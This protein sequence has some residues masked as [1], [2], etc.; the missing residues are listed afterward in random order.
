MGATGLTW[1]R[2][3]LGLRRI[4]VHRHRDPACASREELPRRSELAGHTNGD[5]GSALGARSA[6]TPPG[7]N[8]PPH[9]PLRLPRLAE[10]RPARQCQHSVGTDAIEG[11]AAGRAA[12]A[13][14]HPASCLPA[15]TARR[16]PPGLGQ[17][18][19]PCT[20]FRA[21]RLRSQPEVGAGAW[22]RRSREA[23]EEVR[24]DGGGGERPPRGRGGSRLSARGGAFSPGQSARGRRR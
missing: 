21:C 8:Q 18:S 22:P 5:R 2:G 24:R 1:Q 9:L 3:G 15:P 7:P 4:L 6:Q 19:T 17:R 14:L 12:S 23:A 20:P 16:R 10:Q 13:R 11:P